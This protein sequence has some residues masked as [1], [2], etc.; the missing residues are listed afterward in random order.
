MSR[1]SLRNASKRIAR[2]SGGSAA[3]GRLGGS[4]LGLSGLALGSATFGLSG[5][6]HAQNAQPA[7]PAGQSAHPKAVG[8]A[9]T[10]SNRWRAVRVA[11]SGATPPAGAGMLAQASPGSASQGASAG[12][13]TVPTPTTSAA[14]LQE[15]VVTGIRGSLERAL[16]IKRM[17]LGVVDA[18]S[19]EDIG[20]FPDASIGEAIARI[21]GVTVNRGSVNQMAAAGAPTATGGVSGITIRGFGSQFNELLVEGRPIAY[22]VGAAN[23]QTQGQVFDYSALG[24]EYVGEVDIHKTPDMSLSSGAIGGTVNV[25][26][27]NPFDNPGLHTRAFAA[28]NVN[29]NDGGMRPAFGALLSDTF[30]D[31]KFGILIDGD[32][33]D[34]HV[35]ANHLDIVGWE[36][37]HLACSQF[38]AAPSGSGCASVGTGAAGNSAVPSWYI[39]DMAMYFERTDIRRKDAR[40]SFQWHPTDALLVTLD[41]NF[42]SDDEHT[43][44]WQYSSW[45]SNTGLS[46]VTQD[47]NGTVTNF[48]YGP[49][50]TDFNAFVADT[51][52]V[53]N[54][55]GLNVQWDVSD[56]WSAELDAS[57]SE[58]KLNPNGNYTDVDADTGYGP[59]TSIG[60]NGYIA[61]VAVGNSSTVPYWT[62]FGPG[63]NPANFLGQNP[64]LI[65][66]HVNVLQRQEN[67]DRINQVKL[68]ATWH[69]HG[70]RVNFGAQFVDDL[71]NSN[72]VDDLGGTNNQ[73]QLWSG[74]GPASNNY[75]YYCGSLAT[76]CASQ[77]NPPAGAIRVIHGVS[78]PQGLFTP[79]SLSNFIPGM[80]GNG[81]LPPGL[82]LYSPY[83]VLNYLTTQP[84]NADW[85][86]NPGYPGYSGGYP[87]MALNPSTVQHVDRKNYAPFVTAEHDFQLGGMTLRADLGLRYEKTHEDIAGEEALI[88]SLITNPGDKTAYSFGLNPAVWTPVTNSYGYFLPSLDLNLLVTPRLKLRA[89]FS[90]TE[91]APNDSLLV[92]STT[93]GGRVGSLTVAIANPYLLPYLSD[94]Y[95]LGAEWY[96]AS[97]DYAA[98]DGFFK[99][100]TQFPTS[101]STQ[102]TMPGIVATSPIDP[103]YGGLAEWSQIKNVNGAAAN[104][105][106]VE[107]TWQ[108]MLLWGF[109]FQVN[110]TYV[111]SSANFNP[112][113]YTAT[114][115]ALPG[116]G[117]SAN[118]I[119]FYQRHG[120]QARIAVQWQGK[121]LLQLGQTQP[122]GLFGSNEP[123]YLEASTE[124]DF[125]TTYDITRYLSAYFEA[126]NLTDAEY[127]TVG[128][129][130][131]QLLDAVDYGRSFTLGVRAKF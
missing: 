121:Q 103:N 95:D 13:T 40:A 39:Q 6:L 113:T 115:F 117:N 1:K 38:A 120:L 87:A 16:Q 25:K 127:H 85:S 17:S 49:A 100:V 11:S 48:T 2:T 43:D 35:T 26:F 98:V 4:K 50:P 90:R 10:K 14:T 74:Y 93:Y 7:Q 86:P 78:L 79:I 101:S 20:Q 116:I 110:G 91:S 77:T 107:A 72:E 58:S 108:Q 44:R 92:P 114:Q 124:V 84:I 118:L 18:I 3:A 31:G 64:Y 81:N 94:N 29:D 130:D 66:S 125:S 119:A 59:N 15:I 19:A 83:A 56:H 69:H 8:R 82:L 52:I 60:T 23:G 63:N 76:Q 55:P 61:G 88:N 62:S 129:Y 73:W 24:S 57:Q 27:P 5:L 111:H 28:E 122:N 36:A 65:G 54:T 53:T 32:Y 51:Y 71:W 42:S 21:P 34:Q 70:T 102:V 106:G 80:S 37:E 96:Y 68:D 131:S 9:Q 47:G 126:L 109:G 46:N 33:T 67:S 99:H 97:N 105:T 112:G 22:A 75:E 30:D 123:V 41:D 89:D 104:V 45:F 128:R 12:N